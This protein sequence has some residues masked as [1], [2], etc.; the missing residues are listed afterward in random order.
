MSVG[1]MSRIH[2]DPS[3][4]LDNGEN[5]TEGCLAVT[6]EEDRDRLWQWAIEHQPEL[7]IVY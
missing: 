7:L 4:G 2:Y 6:T 5:G 1:S 3:F